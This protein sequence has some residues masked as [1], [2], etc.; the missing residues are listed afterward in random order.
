MTHSDKISH[1]GRIVQ[2]TPDTTIVEIIS[3]AACSSCHSKKLCSLS[4]SSVKRIEVPSCGWQNFAEGDEVDVQMEL[5]MGA[6]AVVLVYAI[7]LIIMVAVLFVMI[8]AG[9]SEL[10]SGLAALASL[11]VYQLILFLLRGRLRNEMAF[12]IK[13]R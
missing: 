8:L 10:S 11:A 2:I 1:R 7:P 3:E 13:S 6:K 5:S 4:E 9:C 12:K